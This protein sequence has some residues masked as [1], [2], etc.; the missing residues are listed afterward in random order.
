MHQPGPGEDGSIAVVLDD[1]AGELGGEDPAEGGARHALGPSIRTRAELVVLSTEPAVPTDEAST[2]LPGATGSR[3]SRSPLAKSP[4]SLRRTRRTERPRKDRR[5][6][7]RRESTVA[8]CR[9]W[10]RCG[11]RESWPGTFRRPGS[12]SDVRRTAR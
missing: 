3:W 5:G 12:P 6:N 4:R 1:P 7:R 8:R 10:R 2:P 9:P 11:L